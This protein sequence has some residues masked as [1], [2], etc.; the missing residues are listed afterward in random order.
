MEHTTLD[1]LYKEIKSIQR[2]MVTKEELESF[3]ET[4]MILSNEG[5]ISQIE[6]SEKDIVAGRVKRIDS[7]HAI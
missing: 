7:V 2:R 4:V 1:D 6:E 3:I 5:T